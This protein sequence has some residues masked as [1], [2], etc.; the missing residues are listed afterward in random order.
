MI[1]GQP[2]ERRGLLANFDFLFP[3][4]LLIGFYVFY[5]RQMQGGGGRGNGLGKNKAKML[6]ADEV[7]TRF[8]DVAGCDEA[9]VKK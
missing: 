8:S 6:T 1:T 2:A 7:K 9:K 5:M 3:M 4:L